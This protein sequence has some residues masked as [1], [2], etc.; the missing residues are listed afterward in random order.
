MKRRH[1]LAASATLL[2]AG[3]RELMAE[4]LESG[5]GS[6]ADAGQRSAVDLAADLA[7]GKS[8]AEGLMGEALERIERIDRAGPRLNSV[9]ELNPEAMAIA[10][11]LD[12][13]RRSGRSRGP[14]HGLP[15]LLKDNI[16]TGDAMS[17]TAGS[18]ALE[19]VRA[20]RDAEVARR[21]RAAGAVIVGKT[22]LSEWANIR[23]TRSVSGWSG[24][25]GLTRNP[26]ALDR[27]T[28]GSS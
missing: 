27:S 7:A 5:S 11:G 25:G 4:T 9:I 17:T 6:A 22:N 16:A 19:G 12:A 28:S 2:A 15:V 3:S 21:L 26:Y 14:L 10:R 18:L 24:R 8:S 13:E 1:W 23:S 20:Q